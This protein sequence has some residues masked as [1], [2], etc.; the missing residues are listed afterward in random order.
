ML[1][2]KSVTLSGGCLLSEDRASGVGGQGSSCAVFIISKISDRMIDAV[3]F[4]TT[5]LL[6]LIKLVKVVAVSALLLTK[7][8]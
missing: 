5:Y 8:F 4:K 6:S 7:N 2:T 1:V 3:S